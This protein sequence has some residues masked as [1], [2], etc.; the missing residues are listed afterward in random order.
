[1]ETRSVSLSNMG[2]LR[3]VDMFGGRKLDAHEQARVSRSC[4]LEFVLTRI[5]MSRR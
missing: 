3:D 1:M 4:N 5:G 2:P